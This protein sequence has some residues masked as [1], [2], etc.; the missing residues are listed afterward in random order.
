[1]IHVIIKIAGKILNPTDGALIPFLL[2]QAGITNPTDGA[3]IPYIAKQTLTEIFLSYLHDFGNWLI[4]DGVIIGAHFAGIWGMICLLV[5]ISGQG[6]WMERGVK[7]YILS[8]M[9]GLV[10]HAV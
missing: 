7:S 5:A 6:K 2:D 10:Q 8:L 3:I 4:T 9:L 1:V